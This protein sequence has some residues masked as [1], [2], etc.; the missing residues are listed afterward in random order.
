VNNH[1]TSRRSIRD[2]TSTIGIVCCLAI[3]A[4]AAEPQKQL[5][6]DQDGN[7]STSEA[8]NKVVPVS[9]LD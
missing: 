2:L 5:T 6:I 9:L 7:R 8:E 3:T 4:F 1:A